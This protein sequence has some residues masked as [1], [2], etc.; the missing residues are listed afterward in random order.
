MFL[1]EVRKPVTSLHGVGKKV[2][3]RLSRLGIETIAD[4]L[5]L[6]PRHWEDRASI[7]PLAAAEE[8]KPALSIVEVAAHDWIGRP[9][10]QT[11]KIIVR[12]MTGT[13]SLLCFNRNFLGT[14]LKPG[15]RIMLFAHLQHRFGEVQTASFEFEAAPG[16]SLSEI[17]DMGEAIPPE[18]RSSTIGRIF[19]VYPLTEGLNQG[20]LRELMRQSLEGFGKYL[21]D[22]L[23]EEVRRRSG[24]PPAAEALRML[25]RPE[26]MDEALAG[27]R[28]LA[29]QEIFHLQFA[30]TRRAAVRKLVRREP[31]EL[32][33]TM[34]EACKSSLPFSLTGDQ[35]T[36]VSELIADLSSPHP[37][38]RLLQ[39]DVGSGKTLTA[40]LSALPVIEAGCQVA[41]MAPTELLARQHAENAARYLGPLGVRLALFTGSIG[42]ASRK[43]LTQA[44]EAGEIDLVVGT[45]TLFSS[46]VDFKNLRYCIIDEQHKFGVMQRLGLLK[47]GE[48]PDLLMMTATPIPR[49]MALTAF[50]DLSVSAIREL[51][52]GR[53]PVTT[54]LAKLENR[55]KV[56]GAVEKELERGGQAYF[57]YPVIGEGKRESINGAEEM[58]HYL[59]EHMFPHRRLAI[60]HS[61][62]N[63]ERKELEME[64]FLNGETDILIAT[65]VVE[66]GVDAPNATCMVIEHAEQFGLSALH[67]LRGRVGRG[68]R[69]SYC[70]L[71]F[72]ENLTE[73]GKERLRIMKENSDGFIIAEEDLKLRGPGEIAGMRQAGVLAL[74]YADL[75]EDMDLL[76]QSRTA[77]AALSESDPRLLAPEHAVLRRLYRTAP[78]FEDLASIG[79][80]G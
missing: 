51:P 17:T 36:A 73:T 72:S 39:G 70:F 16:H 33:R 38:A 50:G 25:H 35:E 77:A 80:E 1:G 71:V 41:F 5:A 12:D 21:D 28:A 8:E 30:V 78:P 37:M 10:G 9:P 6:P 63:E 14:K 53:K 31:L 11:L 24:F 18:L 59:S 7:V 15:N 3:A 13:A 67:Q 42:S 23:P 46:G 40:F 69:Q 62:I 19:P 32:K 4:L 49:T 29:F 60:L 55:N 75:T 57:V 47:K 79:E 64:R 20:T 61:K 68:D 34:V 52:P 43:Q 45:H 48:M 2:S 58:F 54:H 66:V 27:R 76:E 74:R 22:E 65:S 26:S 44:L 56:Y